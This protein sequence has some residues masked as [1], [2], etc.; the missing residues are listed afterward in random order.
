[1]LLAAGAGALAAGAGAAAG[2]LAEACGVPVPAEVL[3]VLGV[4]VA[5]EVVAAGLG[6]GFGARCGFCAFCVAAM[7]TLAGG[8]DAGEGGGSE[9][10]ALWPLAPPP[11]ASPTTRMMT[12]PTASVSKNGR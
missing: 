4:V 6:L 2:A 3:V 5:V 7:P 9:D 1:L 8:V 11:S 10:A 12:A